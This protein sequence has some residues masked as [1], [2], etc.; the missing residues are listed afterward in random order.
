MSLAK[1]FKKTLLA[2]VI[3]KTLCQ[4]SFAMA[5]EEI[6]NP[7]GI[8]IPVESDSVYFVNLDTDTVIYEKNKDLK[9][10]SS[11]LVKMM[12]SLLV[13]QCEECQKNPEQFLNKEIEAKRYIF[14]RLY[15]TGA[16][17]ADI[18]PGEIITIKDAL[19]GALIASGCE[20][21]MMLVDYVWD[22]NIENCVL[23]MNKKAKEYNM[24]N[25]N[26]TDAD[27][28]DTDNQFTTAYDMYLLTKECIKNEIFKKIA[29][30]RTYEMPPTNK[31]PKPTT[32]I[33]T[34]KL[35]N[36]GSGCFDER[37][38]GIKTGNLQDK[39]N[40]VSI[41][42]NK[43][44]YSYML[45]TLGAP[46]TQNVLYSES[47]SLYKWAFSNLKLEILAIPDEKTVPNNIKINL[48]K[49]T[50]TIILTPK[51][52]VTLLLPKSIDRTTIYWDTSNLPKELN[53]PIAKGKSIG[54]VNLM[55]S[56]Q[57]IGRVEVISAKDIDLDILSYVEYLA[58]KFIFS[59]KFLV[60]MS[61]IL[62][63]TFLILMNRKFL[64]KSRKKDKRYDPPF[65]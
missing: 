25:T 34:N 62:I 41:A 13:L 15:K 48:A 7:Y 37:V 27:G 65:K 58:K 11:A 9:V 54:T 47:K 6:K 29:T 30:S 19:Y 60:I 59:W 33:H 63:F 28:L 51:D 18:R 17:T 21:T 53:A 8:D 56:D 57:E 4:F 40:L 10:P 23:A 26:F 16:S 31:H 64:R 24:E 5:T 55:L 12:S 35:M 45:I 1:I 14:D 42:V 46:K 38:R 32:L 49:N 36:K 61:F 22:G 39:Q 50:D 44:K 43:E 52:Q 20:A 3:L 2:L